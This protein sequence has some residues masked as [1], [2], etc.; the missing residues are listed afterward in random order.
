MIQATPE[1]TVTQIVGNFNEQG[2]H[3]I[4]PW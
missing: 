1:S 2:R 3:S 4:Q